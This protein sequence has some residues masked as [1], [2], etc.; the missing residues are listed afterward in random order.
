MYNK[1]AVFSVSCRGEDD[2][3]EEEAPEGVTD[4][5]G[6]YDVSSSES[7]LALNLF[8]PNPFQ[9]PFLFLSAVARKRRG[10]RSGA[11]SDIF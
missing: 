8:S 11:L 7:N 5:A 2:E 1:L 10:L 4:E 6:Q 9:F 3:E